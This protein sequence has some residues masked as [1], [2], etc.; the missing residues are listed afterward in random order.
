M[1]TLPESQLG[2][3]KQQTNVRNR[4]G[5]EMLPDLLASVTFG[6]TPNNGLEEVEDVTQSR[7][8]YSL[9]KDDLC[10]N[11]THKVPA[12]PLWAKSKTRQTRNIRPSGSRTFIFL[13][14]CWVANP[15]RQ[16]SAVACLNAFH[17]SA[18]KVLLGPPGRKILKI[19][20]NRRQCNKFDRDVEI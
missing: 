11:Q 15:C 10:A 4:L 5:Q 18:L 13:P 3:R 19:V 9:T 14:L 12:R 7:G 2:F 17:F 1:Y 20:L 8:S 6:D 16:R